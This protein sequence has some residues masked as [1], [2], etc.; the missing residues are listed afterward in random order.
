MNDLRRLKGDERETT[1]NSY[2]AW[3]LIRAL[4]ELDVAY[5]QGDFD[6]ASDV[7]DEIA[8]IETLVNP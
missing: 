7:L 3:R 5:G 8:S 6:T 2:Y 4:E 1:K